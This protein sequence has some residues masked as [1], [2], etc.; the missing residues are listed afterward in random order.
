MLRFILCI[1]RIYSAYRRILQLYPVSVAHLLAQRKEAR[2]ITTFFD[3]MRKFAWK[4][5]SH[6]FLA[7]AGRFWMRQWPTVMANEKIEAGRISSI[8]SGVFSLVE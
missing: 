2:I 1:L 8:K 5:P 7:A 3:I 6:V 4:A